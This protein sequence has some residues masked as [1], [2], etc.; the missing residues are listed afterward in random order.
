MDEKQIS[1]FQQF[2]ELFVIAEVDKT[3]AA[4]IICIREGIDSYASEN[5]AWFLNNYSEF[6]YIDRIVVDK[7]FRGLGIG[8]KLYEKVFEHAAKT[9]VEFV[10]A[11]IDLIPYNESSLKFH[12]KMGFKEVGTQ[13]VRD[14]T[15][16]VSLQQFK[17]D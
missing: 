12:E 13:Y 5:Y 2:C 14:G 9:G 16:K 10:T 15:V 7:A 1:E 8:K 17:I 6:L 4:F 11:E 3:P